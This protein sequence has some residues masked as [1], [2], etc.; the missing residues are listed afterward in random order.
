LNRLNQIFK[1]A[2][3][4]HD[5][6]KLNYPRNVIKTIEKSHLPAI[7]IQNN[8]EIVK[9]VPTDYDLEMD[10]GAVLRNCDDYDKEIGK[11]IKNFHSEYQFYY[12]IE[13]FSEKFT[14][15]TVILFVSNFRMIRDKNK[16][17]EIMPIPVKVK[18]KFDKM[19]MKN[20]IYFSDLNC[21]YFLKDINKLGFMLN[22]N[23]VQVLLH[24]LKYHV[25][26]LDLSSLRT[27]KHHMTELVK[28]FGDIK[29]HKFINELVKNLEL[30]LKYSIMLKLKSDTNT[31]TITNML[32]YFTNDLTQI[33]YDE[34]LKVLKFNWKHMRPV[35]IV[36]LLESLASRQYKHILMLDLICKYIGYN[37]N[38]FNSNELNMLVQESFNYRILNALNKLQ[39]YDGPIVEI[40]VEDILKKI[41]NSKTKDSI[42]A[43]NCLIASCINLN[44]HANTNIIDYFKN[45][46]ISDDSITA[47]YEN[48]RLNY[49]DFIYYAAVCN[50]KKY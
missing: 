18:E 49:H 31:D 15:R 34:I 14:I 38:S 29:E 50:Y 23:C 32:V 10:I 1:I 45:N 5:T 17:A 25:N 30:A 22:D 11:L 44:L 26:S 6:V 13:N 35:S 27:V 12:L 46:Y 43:I 41:N 47:G 48:V 21:A 4:Y 37:Y 24:L 16:I 36:K 19:F 33:Q 9:S 3:C 39:F 40:L 42:N 8:Q 20:G 2:A 28:R 7:Q